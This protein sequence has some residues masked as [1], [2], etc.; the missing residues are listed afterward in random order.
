MVYDTVIQS[1]LD[2]IEKQIT[3]NIRA[4]ELARAANYSVYHF[5]R[6]FSEITGTPVSAYIARRK[7]EYALY[8]LSKGRKVIPL[9]HDEDEVYTQNAALQ[10]TWKY[11]LENWLPESEYEYDDTRMDYKYHDERAHSDWRD[12]GKCC[13]RCHCRLAKTGKYGYPIFTKEQLADI[14][15][16]IGNLIDSIEEGIATASVK[17]RLTDLIR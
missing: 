7:L 15:K 9:T 16:R 2:D 4:G 13:G 17:Q 3:E 10:D 12:D 5:S 6:V 8:E 14:D 11:I 1:A